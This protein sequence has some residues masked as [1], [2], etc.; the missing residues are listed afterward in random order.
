M[1]LAYFTFDGLD[2]LT[3]LNRGDYNTQT[4]WHWAELAEGS[5]S[6]NSIWHERTGSGG[7]TLEKRSDS[8]NSI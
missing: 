1:K 3:A 2:R 7:Q 6:K 4:G 8:K 5:D